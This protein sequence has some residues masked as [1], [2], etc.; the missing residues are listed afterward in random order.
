MRL[1]V[2]KIR[3]KTQRHQQGNTQE[4]PKHA[5]KIPQLE[6]TSLFVCD[7][8]FFGGVWGCFFFFC[9]CSKPPRETAA[10]SRECWGSTDRHSRPR[11]GTLGDKKLTEDVYIF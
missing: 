10:P 9:P 3:Y 2:W 4:Y 8:D 7:C 1:I 6:I 5:S 11:L